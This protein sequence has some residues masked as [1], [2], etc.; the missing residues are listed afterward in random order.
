[1][2]VEIPAITPVLR[3]PGHVWFGFSLQ[4]LDKSFETML[5]RVLVAEEEGFDSVWMMDHLAPLYDFGFDGKLNS[6]EG[7]TFATALAARTTRIRVGHA[8]L[9]SEHRH[10]AMLARMVAT[11]DVVSGGRLDLGVGWGSGPGEL[12]RYGFGT[13]SNR[14]RAARL[15]ETLEILQLMLDCE[16]FDYEGTYYT[17]RSALGA[18]RPVQPKIPIF[19]GGRGPELTL[20]LVR[21]FADWWNCP[22]GPS[23]RELGASVVPD[24]EQPI[25]S[26]RR[27]M[28]LP[29]ALGSDSS[30]ARAAATRFAAR[31]PETRRLPIV[32]GTPDEIVRI[33]ADDVADGVEGFIVQFHDDGAPETL[34]TFMREVAPPLR[35][36]T[37]R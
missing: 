26:A 25:G 36:L 29:I 28:M 16:P 5:E 32:S 22:A 11:L 18:P 37:V 14:E 30:A 13:A 23:R 12:Q 15:R 19:I 33:L 7:W 9:C 27:S 24:R 10:P 35:D 21:D 34:R 8:V 2:T 17:L 3:P 31:V 20:P 1:M 4:Q 6:F